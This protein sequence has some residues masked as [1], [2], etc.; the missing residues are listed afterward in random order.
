MFSPIPPFSNVNLDL[1]FLLFS[2]TSDEISFL[3]KVSEIITLFNSP[4]NRTNVFPPNFQ[5]SIPFLSQK[6][7]SFNSKSISIDNAAPIKFSKKPSFFRVQS[8]LDKPKMITSLCQKNKILDFGFVLWRAV[9]ECQYKGS[10]AVRKV[11]F[12]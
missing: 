8:L 9:L 6:K 11:Q 7:P 5:L 12:F 4:N 2:R 3:K 1:N 10:L